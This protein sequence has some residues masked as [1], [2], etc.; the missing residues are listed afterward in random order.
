VLLLVLLLVPAGTAA[1]YVGPGAGFGLASSLLVFLNAILVSLGSLLAWPILL[2]ARSVKRSRRTLRPQARRVVVLGLDGLSPVILEK[3]FAEGLLPAFRSLPVCT[4]LATTCPGISPVAWS[5]FQTGVNPGGHGIFDF[6]APDRKRYLPVLSSVRTEPGRRGRSTVRLLRRSRPF[7]SYLGRYGIRSTVLRVPITYPPE[8]LDGFLVSGMCVPDLRGTQGTYSLFDCDPG[9]AAGG[10]GTEVPGGRHLPLESSSPGRWTCTLDGPDIG[11]RTET[12]G[13]TLA[14]GTRQGWILRTGG[15]SH[16]LVEGEYTPWIRFAF[17]RGLSRAFGIARFLLVLREGSPVLY[18]TALHPDPWS[19]PVPLGYPVTYPRYLAG[20]MGPFATM[21][22]AEDTWALS[23]GAIGEGAFLAQAW[24]IFEERRLMFRE[25][26]RRNRDGLVVCV[27]DT[28]DRIQHMFWRDGTGP[29]TP[30]RAMYER[31]DAL[32]AETI[33]TLSARDMLVVMSDHGFTSFDW[34]LDI[35]RWLVQAGFMTLSEGVEE[36]R[37]SFA[38]VDWSMTKAYSLGLAGIMLNLRGRESSGIV[39]P[40]DEAAVLMDGIARSLLELTGPSGERVVLEVHRSGSI[41][42]GPYAGDGPD[43]VLGLAHG[44]RAG[45]SCA[46]GG[47]GRE[48]LYR[49]DRHWN[50]DHCQESTLVPGVL[51][52]NRPL[53]SDGAGIL[54]IAPTVLAALGVESPSHMEG[55][56]LLPGLDR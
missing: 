37:D 20:V 2:V 28:S 4:R 38:G 45:W 14:Y 54:D 3:L 16:R 47:V 49:N 51:A 13:I 6:L 21:G 42:R 40:G 5:S 27:F 34:C 30:V 23:N 1:A 33:S 36:V 32:L 46:T 39:E 25:A 53:T 19:P 44:F 9:T 35:N 52:C 24:S 22:L 50:G 48:M 15:R 26:L 43:L 8:P 7:W 11:G 55:R 18:S 31:M 41:Y 17:G 29:G 12:A 10:T 56:S